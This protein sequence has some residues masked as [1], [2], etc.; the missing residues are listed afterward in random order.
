[1]KFI[2]YGPHPSDC[3][4]IGKIAVCTEQPTSL[5][6][7]ATGI[8]VYNLGACVYA[9]VRTPCASYLDVFVGDLSEC[10]LHDGLYTV[11]RP[12]RLPTV[13]RGS[14]VLNAKSNAQSGR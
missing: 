11:T 1:M 9:G 10:L 2:G 5:A 12:L 7:I 6:A 3:D 4:V 14:V 8:G 13:V